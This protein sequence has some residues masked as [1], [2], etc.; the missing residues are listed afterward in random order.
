MCGKKWVDMLSRSSLCVCGYE[1]DGED[2]RY[3]E[4]GGNGS[5]TIGP[6]TRVDRGEMGWMLGGNLKG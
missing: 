3:G 5:P 6:P 4:S 2:W 1:E